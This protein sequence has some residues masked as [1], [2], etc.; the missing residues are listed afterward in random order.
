MS[1]PLL[2]V[3]VA[4]AYAERQT[5]LSTDVPQGTTVRQAIERSGMP[6]RHPEIDLEQMRVGIFGKLCKLDDPVRQGDR[7]E[8]YRP[9]RA[10]PK[11]A[12]RRRAEQSGQA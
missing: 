11:Q 12:R 6:E 5:V 8:I 4:F 7:V 2:R 3:A 1:G 9:L 10:D